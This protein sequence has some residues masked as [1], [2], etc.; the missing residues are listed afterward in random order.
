MSEVDAESQRRRILGV[1]AEGLGQYD[2]RRIDIIHSG[3]GGRA[4][5]TVLQE[6]ERLQAAGLVDRRP[7][8]RSFGDRWEITEEGERV[9]FEAT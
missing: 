9:L 2:A 8:P 7:D 5:G 6:L 1:V 4:E 3:R